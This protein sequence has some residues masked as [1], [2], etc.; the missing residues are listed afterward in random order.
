MHVRNPE[1]FILC[2]IFKIATHF[3][4]DL[5]ALFNKKIMAS[6]KELLQMDL[7]GLLGVEGKATEKEVQ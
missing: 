5:I 2:Y 3:F 4:N 1:A 6:T 7:Y